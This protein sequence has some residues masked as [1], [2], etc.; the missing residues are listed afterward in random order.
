MTEMRSKYA[1]ILNEN[2]ILYMPSCLVVEMMTKLYS[3][4]SMINLSNSIIT[5]MPDL[6]ILLRRL[7]HNLRTTA[8]AYREERIRFFIGDWKTDKLRARKLFF[9]LMS[10]LGYMC[11]LLG[12]VD[13]NLLYKAIEE[14]SS[15]WNALDTIMEQKREASRCLYDCASCRYF[16]P[17]SADN[18]EQMM[19]K[20][21]LEL[22]E[23]VT[24]PDDETYLVLLCY[25]RIRAVVLGAIQEL[26]R[27][28]GGARQ[29]EPNRI[30][31]VSNEDVPITC[32]KCGRMTDILRRGTTAIFR[33]DY[34]NAIPEARDMKSGRRE[35]ATAVQSRYPMPPSLA[36]I[37]K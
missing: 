21:V 36:G 5:V 15:E 18:W 16:R 17:D 8:T 30:L 14:M 20:T 32:P 7:T 34:A 11:Q 10:R 9:N 26:L 2:K 24:Y 28:T 22:D 12:T 23:E 19:A 3:Q 37:T 13:R 25:E 27:R 6:L 31:S 29:F 1:N 35:S 4:V 33:K